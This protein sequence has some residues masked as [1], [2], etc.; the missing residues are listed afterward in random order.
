MNVAMLPKSYF[1]PEAAAKILFIGKALQILRRRYREVFG[2]PTAP[3]PA[4]AAQ[5]FRQHEALFG[6]IF[7][8]LKRRPQFDVYLLGKAI[9]QIRR[10]VAKHLWR[11]VVRIERR[12][13]V[14]MP[15]FWWSRQ[16]QEG[17][18][19]RRLQSLKDLFLMGKGHF[20]QARYCLRLLCGVS[21][22]DCSSLPHAIILPEFY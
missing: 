16:V 9:E 11:V 7:A 12:V 8:A 15:K 14:R 19:L 18:L 10:I 2:G 20:F 17:D 4:H 1:P 5:Q 13:S 6:R 21:A 3:A 22:K